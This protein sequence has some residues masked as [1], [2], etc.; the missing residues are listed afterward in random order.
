MSGFARKMRRLSKTNFLS[1]FEGYSEREVADRKKADF[2][3]QRGNLSEAETM[4]I[5]IVKE[6]RKMREALMRDYFFGETRTTI[7]SLVRIIRYSTSEK[8]V[9]QNPDKKLNRGT[10]IFFPHHRG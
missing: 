5:R 1:D 7:L 6:Q 2:V 8:E 3:I 9:W 10:S 4:W